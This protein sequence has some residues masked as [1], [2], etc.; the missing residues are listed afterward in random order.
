MA[1]ERYCALEVIATFFVFVSHISYALRFA[2]SVKPAVCISASISRLIL[3]VRAQMHPCPYMY[4]I[5]YM[6]KSAGN[7]AIVHRHFGVWT[8]LC[9][10]QSWIV[11]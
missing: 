10:Y 1:Q 9:F 6:F 7:H 8:C 4:T 2:A 3:R 11:V 5:N